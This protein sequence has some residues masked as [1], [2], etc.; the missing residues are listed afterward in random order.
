MRT[1]SE[2]IQIPSFIERFRYLKLGGR[3]GEETFGVDRWINQYLYQRRREWKEVRQHVILRDNACDL[4]HPGR[5][6]HERL[7]IHHMNPITKEDILERPDYVLDPEY[8][9]ATVFN[10]HNAIHYGD[11]SLITRF[12]II[13]RRPFDT[14]PW[15]M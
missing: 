13:E 6:T 10:T 3:V 14:C 15:K 9:I 8:L 11:E 1:Y 4:A 12:E 2:L 7:Y 5:P